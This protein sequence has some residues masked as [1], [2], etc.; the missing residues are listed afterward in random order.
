[1][2]SPG[3]TSRSLRPPRPHWSPL[4]DAILRERA[5]EDTVLVLSRRLGRSTKGIRNRLLRLG[6]QQST[7]QGRVCLQVLVR[8]FGLSISRIGEWIGKGLSTHPGPLSGRG[9]QIQV[10]PEE[11]LAFLQSH[12]EAWDPSRV[13]PRLAR[14]YGVSLPVTQP[15]TPPPRSGKATGEKIRD[16][17]ERIK[18]GKPYSPRE[19]GIEGLMRTGQV[20]RVGRGRYVA[21]T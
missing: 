8:V 2:P 17:L 3:H 11:L 10:T 13:S 15:P 6:I 5:G 21:T 1:M 12:P 9:R 4:E 20:Q 7:Q 14:K 19:R 16:L 18:T